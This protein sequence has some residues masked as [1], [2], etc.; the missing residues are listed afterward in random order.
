MTKP[1]REAI[2]ATELLS[3]L[4]YERKRLVMALAKEHN[5]TPQQH[6]A[7]WALAPGQRLAM[8]ELADVLM[9]DASNVTG[10]VDK[11]EARGLAQREQGEDRRVKVLVLTAAGEKLREEMVAR[12]HQVPR[13]ISE[14]SRDDQRT[15]RDL[16]KRGPVSA[17]TPR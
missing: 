17:A 11:L 6:S 9:C 2:E 14:L 5:L 13:W 3:E 15:L 10:I 1:S 8:S 16:L 7:L 12:I 4:F